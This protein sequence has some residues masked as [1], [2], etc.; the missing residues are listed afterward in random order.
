MVELP[1][2]DWAAIEVKLGL[3]AED[4]AAASLISI[5]DAIATEPKGR[6]PKS[7]IVIVGMSGSAYR[8]K[9]GVIVCPLSALRP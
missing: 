3:G 5:R 9:D 6:P 8:R 1:D 2:G 7:L 4:A